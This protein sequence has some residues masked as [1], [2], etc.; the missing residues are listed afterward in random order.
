M[1]APLLLPLAALALAAAGCNKTDPAIHKK[2]AELE[3]QNRVAVERQQ[4]LERQLAEQRLATER[5]AIERDRQRIEDERFALEQ[6]QSDEAAAKQAALA[7]REQ[8]LARREG[9]LVGLETTLEEQQLDLGHRDD[10][11]SGRELELAGRE[12]LAVAEEPAQA[13]PVGDYGMFFDALAAYGSWLGTSGYGYVWQPAV[14]VQSGW[15]PYYN[16]R[17]ACTNHGWTWLS[18]EPFGWACYHYGRWARLHDR[19]WVWVPGDQWA[20]AWVCWRENGS[21]IGWAPLPPE[22]LGWRDCHWDNTIETRFGIGADWFNFVETSHFGGPIRGHCLPLAENANWH[23]QTVNTT[24]ILCRNRHVFVGGP[25]YQNLSRDAGRP[26]PY[27]RLNL[28]RQQRPGHNPLVMRPRIDGGQLHVAAPEVGAGWNATLRPTKVREQLAEAA[29]DRRAPLDAEVAAQFR[30]HREQELAKAE[31]EVAR[32]GGLA[33]FNRSHTRELEA[34]QLAAA[35]QAKQPVTSAIPDRST[36]PDRQPGAVQ[37]LPGTV[38][39]PLTRSGAKPGSGPVVRPQPTPA[40]PE[41]LQAVSQRATEEARQRDEA[42]LKEQRQR[43]YERNA[44][45]LAAQQEK[46]AAL[47]EQQEAARIQQA[48]SAKLQR[49]AQ[50]IAREAQAALRAKV[51]EARQQKPATANQQP[52]PQAANQRQPTSEPSR[53]NQSAALRTQQA[54]RQRQADEAR[55]RQQEALRT[56]QAASQRQADEARARQQEAL[57]TQQ[58]ASQRQA[59]EA[60][61]R[62]QETLR[63]QQ[64]ASA[65]QQESTRRQTPTPPMPS[66]VSPP[67]AAPASSSPA[68]PS[69]VSPPPAS[70]SPATPGRRS[71]P[72]VPDRSPAG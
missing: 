60:R 56:Q 34:N 53:Q 72:T 39:P 8:S 70:S 33:A 2:L 55:T 47:K 52:E 35:T 38:E 1:K 48:E 26:L 29:I 30:R 45:A 25:D 44:A 3:D 9:R 21:H 11:I 14:V 12:P 27:Y 18:D 64:A 36:R 43:A 7:E 17:W 59:D 40:M 4:A 57:R 22:T 49:G 50:A 65:R 54:T 71:S 19:G 32:L 10:L 62:Q 23:R 46:L 61:A 31:Q 41:P 51:E 37:P 42:A 5:D 6:D 68:T 69:R 63:T 28:D 13:L 20:P 16:G 24:N 67:P 58:T 66:R 15:R